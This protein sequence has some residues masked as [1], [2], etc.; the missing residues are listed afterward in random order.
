MKH[1]YIPPCAVVSPRDLVSNVHVI[2]DGGS[3]LSVA[4]LNWGK[5]QQPRIAI[6]WNIAQ[7]EWEDP[8]KKSG[9]TVCVGMPTSRGHAVWFLLPKDFPSKDSRVRR[10]IERACKELA[11]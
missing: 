9:K 5:H 6:R 11:P 1:K 4:T 3:E 7:R 2:L 8:D 10:A